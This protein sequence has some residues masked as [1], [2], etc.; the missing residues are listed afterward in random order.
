[1]ITH[2]PHVAAAARRQVELRDGRVVA[3]TGETR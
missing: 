1:V 3:E 2:D